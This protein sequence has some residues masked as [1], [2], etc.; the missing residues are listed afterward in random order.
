MSTC[1][2]RRQG[3]PSSHPSKRAIKHSS[4]PERKQTRNQAI[5][6]AR[7]QAV[8]QPD[9]AAAHRE[10]EAVARRVAR[11]RADREVGPRADAP[12]LAHSDRRAAPPSSGRGWWVLVGPRSPSSGA[13][14][15]PLGGGSTGCP[16]PPSISAAACA[17]RR[18][19]SISSSLR[20]VALSVA[21]ISWRARAPARNRSRRSP[22]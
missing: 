4:S 14:K 19:R 17:H 13:G 7:D 1:R 9:G 10:Q 3:E 22:S 18:G 2:A 11:R 20:P 5:K 16:K 8:V 12:E 15:P 21:C 6:R